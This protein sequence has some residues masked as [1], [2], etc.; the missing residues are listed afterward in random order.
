MPRLFPLHF[1]VPLAVFFDMKLKEISRTAATAWAPTDYQLEDHGLSALMCSG[2]I[3][4]A[5]D[6]SFSST[7]DLEIFAMPL[8]ASTSKEAL[9]L[10]NTSVHTR[11]PVACLV[12]DFRFQRLAWTSAGVGSADRPL[13][14]ILGGMDDGSLDLWN[15][16]ALLHKCA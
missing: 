5:M 7:T 3:A 8:G 11:Y 14:M 13:G 1:P 12:A 15:P 10:A 6:D 2:S 4:G 9:R 16:H